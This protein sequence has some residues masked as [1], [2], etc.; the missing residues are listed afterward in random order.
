MIQSLRNEQP[1]K[2]SVSPML[3]NIAEKGR[4][5]FFLNMVPLKPETIISLGIPMSDYSSWQSDRLSLKYTHAVASLM[6]LHY[7]LNTPVTEPLLAS[8]QVQQTI[9]TLLFPC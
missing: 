9:S 5:F 1:S 2:A 3:G 6:L 4:I 8:C 7:E